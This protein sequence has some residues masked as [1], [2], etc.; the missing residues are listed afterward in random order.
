MTRDE[1]LKCI[2]DNCEAFKRTLLAKASKI[3]PNWDSVE[4]RQW[5]MD[6]IGTKW[7]S[8]F[9]GCN[10]TLNILVAVCFHTLVE[11]Q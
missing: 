9:T 8:S 10:R 4:I 2:E 7:R 3:L 11:L 6:S 5:V 1:Q